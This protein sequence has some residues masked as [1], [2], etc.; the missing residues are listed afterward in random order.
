MK[1]VICTAAILAAFISCQKKN[2]LT[3]EA[4]SQTTE[5]TAT[6]KTNHS[7]AR[8]IPTQYRQFSRIQGSYSCSGKDGNC[9][10]DVV[11]KPKMTDYILL[12]N[13]ITT[14]KGGNQQAIKQFFEVNQ[15]ALSIYMPTE[16]I[17]AVLAGQD[18]PTWYIN[19]DGVSNYLL[20][21]NKGA[22]MLVL[23]LIQ[24]L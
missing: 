12:T 15:K 16:E 19:N 10:P 23:P 5:T 20:F 7:N 9:L 3:A 18:I 4:S 22:V 1:K 14:V 6:T 21:T 8:T 11:V 17:Q 2:K 24:Q 13:L